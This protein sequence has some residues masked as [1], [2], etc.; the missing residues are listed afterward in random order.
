M[1]VTI[2]KCFWAELLLKQSKGSELQISCF[3]SKFKPTL[4]TL[5][6]SDNTGNT[7]QKGNFL[8]L[9]CNIL[10]TARCRELINGENTF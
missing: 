2:S 7:A 5:I 4:K 9:K 6:F 3:S 10:K 1:F 8:T